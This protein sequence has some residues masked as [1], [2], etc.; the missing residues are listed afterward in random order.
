MSASVDESVKVWEDTPEGLKYNYTYQGHSL[1]VVSVATS[2]NGQYAASSALDSVIRVWSLTDHS[3]AAIIEVSWILFYRHA[4]TT[5]LV[6]NF[7][8]CDHSAWLTSVVQHSRYP[9]MV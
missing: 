4:P 7:R 3:T 5:L 6:G 2:A 8:I 1:G 9:E